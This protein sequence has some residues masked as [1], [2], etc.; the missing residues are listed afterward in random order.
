MDGIHLLLDAV[1]FNGN[2]LGHISEQGVEW[3]GNDA[4]FLEL[5]AAQVR[6]AAIKRILKKGAT[7]TIKY[8]LIELL[9]EQ[10][11][12]TLGGSIT[13]TGG[14]EAPAQ[15]RSIEGELKILTGTGQT[16]L[17][18]RATLS[19]ALRGSLGG[20]TPLGVSCT[21]DVLAPDDG[22]APLSIEET[23]PFIKTSP[24]TLNFAKGGESHSFA[25]EASGRFSISKAPAGFSV[26]IM[27]SKVTIKATA[28]GTTSPRT[29]QLTLTLA[30][31]PS[32]T[33]TVQLTQAG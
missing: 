18:K 10:L 33:A 12:A 11:V 22:S 7:N 3:T 25:I 17:I 27:G 5:H 1:Y 16:I 4:E 30:D 14:W 26:S 29:G 32:T 24:T 28:N 19:A 20:D 15:A 6:N 2:K 23:R 21:H 13:S 8:T 31:H 9:P